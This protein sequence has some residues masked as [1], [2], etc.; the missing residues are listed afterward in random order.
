MSEP[1]LG[2][3]LRRAG[4]RHLT[5]ALLTT[6]VLAGC[7]STDATPVAPDASSTA[8][9]HAFGS[10]NQ[11]S[12]T[13]AEPDTSLSL[14]SPEG[15][16]VADGTADSYVSKV[17]YYVAPASCYT[18]RSS[19]GSNDSSSEP[20]SVLSRDSQ[21][22][23]DA[24]DRT[25]LH[26]GLNYVP[27]RDGVELAVTV[28]P[29]RGKT[30]A[31][32]PF[33]TVV[34]YSGYP[35]A[36]PHD[37]LDSIVARMGHPEVSRDPLVP[38]TATAIGAIIAPQLQ[39]TTVSVQM[40]GSGCS[41]G[42][43]DLFGLPTIYDGYDIVEIAAA[44]KWAKGHRV[45]MVGISYS[46]FSQ[47]FVA[48]TR[49]PHL[50]AVAPF[51]VTADLYDGIG[52]PGGV[53]N[54]GFAQ[55]WLTERQSDAR[56]APEGGQ[57]WAK[58]L[59]KQG[60]EHCIASQKLHGQARDALTILENSPFR[61][62]Y[63]YADRTPGDWAKNI[64]VPMFLVGGL[65]DEQ[66]GSHWAS[67]IPNLHTEKL[68]L[69]LYNGNHNDALQPD[70]FTKWYEFLSIYLAEEVPKI[71][72]GFMGLSSAF[73]K[74]FAHAPSPPL[75]QSEFAGRTDFEAVK[76]EFERQPRVRM[77]V[78]VGST[79]LGPGSFG[80]AAETYFDS[81]PPKAAQPR[82]W[83]FADHGKL[84]GQSPTNS[85]TDTYRADTS[86]RPMM[87][88][89]KGSSVNDAQPKWQYEPVPDGT[90]VAYITDPMTADVVI[91]GSGSVDVELSANAPD[92]DVQ[93]GLTEVTPDGNEVYVGSGWL[94]ASHRKLNTEL[95]S[96][97]WPVATHLKAD[98]AP[99]IAD[100][101]NLLRVPIYPTYAQIRAGSRLRIAIS[102][103]GGDRP[104]W[105][106]KTIETGTT[107]VSIFRGGTSA[108]SL[109]LPVITT[110]AV[111]PLPACGSL[112]GQPCRVY[113]PA[114]NGG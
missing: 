17:F 84:E 39:M 22:S 71:S 50:A 67:L 85:G 8:N 72:D 112:R 10:I 6:A 75:K 91:A 2:C 69:T 96:E 97:L 12:V 70:I 103:P 38:A 16:V 95:S 80:A 3:H 77:L 13:G 64:D 87:D 57:D 51:S 94:R 55:G 79:S 25:T 30:L 78:D 37:L 62:P 98:A 44:Q 11:A 54:T 33:P 106:F 4:T 73:F 58:E 56:P 108:S 101:P 107:Q 76:A 45:A 53:F 110:K 35:T 32:G 114:T 100:S 65:H 66:L 19:V 28:R 21:P 105:N 109:V 82:R 14:V 1:S 111:D 42:A 63:L 49:P 74:E 99:L 90:G 81:W 47:L 24:Y 104:L 68:W 23:Q 9:F 60:D 88:L 29:P 26:E 36:G 52:S 48:G 40:R 5:M 18:V 113:R 27:M 89:E 86:Q 59:V 15:V 41:G 102:A 61:D 92:T 34:E 83:Y 7:T 31:D 93:V 43:F 46:G 20:F